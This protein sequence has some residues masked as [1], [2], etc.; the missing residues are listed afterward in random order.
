MAARGPKKHLKRLNAPTHWMLDKLTGVWAPRPSTGPHKLRECLP[1]VV[2]LRNRLKYALTRREVILIVMQRLVKVDGKVRTDAT[3]PAGLMDV[4]TIEK[5]GENF[6]LVYDEKGRFQAVKIG[7]KA[8]SFKL[9]KVVRQQLGPRGIPYIVT[10]DGRTI[11]YP[12]P[13]IRVN[14]TVKID[15]ATGKVT[16]FIKFAV[17]NICMVTSG[18]NIG[19][20]GVLHDK[21]HHAGGFD[22]V[23]IRDDAGRE[24][25]T[26]LN[27]V[28]ILG[29]DKPWI[30]LPNNKGIK[31][32]IF[33]DRERR[34][35]NQTTQSL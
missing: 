17:G 4:V 29:D 24:F 23:H 11:R 8:A 3:Y 18:R 32:D 1:L 10:H 27:N 2:L 25:A 34:M 30:K 26:R 20:V 7:A 21:E 31:A 35:N 15:I 14:D 6:R 22:I 13:D 9:G 33:E 5:S 19:R 28:F 12:D 16:K